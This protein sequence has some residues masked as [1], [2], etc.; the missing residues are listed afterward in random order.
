MKHF[1]LRIITR[2]VRGRP[3]T[4]A[5][6]RV[7]ALRCKAVARLVGTILALAGIVILS[8]VAIITTLAV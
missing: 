2:H 4:V 6:L 3:C 1:I 8:L 7:T 5:Q